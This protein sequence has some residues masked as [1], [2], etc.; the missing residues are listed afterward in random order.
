M[1]LI[2]DVLASSCVEVG[3]HRKRRPVS[4]A[5]CERYQRSP[6]ALIS[7][8]FADPVQASCLCACANTRPVHPVYLL[9]MPLHARPIYRNGLKCFFLVF[10]RGPIMAI[11]K[12]SKLHLVIYF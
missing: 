1:P 10:K 3:I 6:R 4:S 7:A 8:H 9:S 2:R 5:T 11:S 12:F